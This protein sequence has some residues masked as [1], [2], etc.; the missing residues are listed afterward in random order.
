MIDVRRVVVGGWAWT[1]LSIYFVANVTVSARWIDP[2]YSPVRNMISDL[3]ATECET[4][5]GRAVCSPWHLTVDTAWAISGL[6]IIVGA[7]GFAEIA[8]ADPRGR[9]G[10]V[11]LGCSGLGLLIIATS[12]ENLRPSVH[13][14]GAIVA[15]TGGV[16]GM[17]LLSWA[18]W[19]AHRWPLLAAAG[20]VV[21]P[22]SVIGN[23]GGEIF[24]SRITGLME[25]IGQYP[26]LLWMI[27]CGVSVLAAHGVRVRSRS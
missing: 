16:G 25:R 10:T 18:L 17:F 12:P 7:W 1:A 14:T 3:G 4:I 27:A 8:P 24:N 2:L 20:L 9:W 23:A 11:L 13:V 5:H 19:R 21:A 15:A 22:F 26:Y 6:L